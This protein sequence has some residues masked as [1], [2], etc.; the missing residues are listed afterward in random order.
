[1][2]GPHPQSHV[3]LWN[4]GHVINKT[5]YIS[6]FTRPMNP[7]LSSVVTKDAGS[8]PTKSCNTSITWSRDKS[9]TF[10]IHIHKAHGL[11][12]LIGCWIRMRGLH[13]KSDVTL[14][15]CGH[16]KNEKRHISSTTGLSSLFSPK[17]NT[18]IL[19]RTTN[20]EMK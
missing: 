13:P 11:Q 14:Q 8:P 20:V 19:T 1:M 12:N 2:R 6:T 15:S 3:T 9:K 7:K 4:C 18:K 16:V 10:Y 5:C 17:I